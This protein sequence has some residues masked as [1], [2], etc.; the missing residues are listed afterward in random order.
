MLRLSLDPERP[1]SKELLLRQGRVIGWLEEAL[2]PLADDIGAAAVHALAVAIRSAIGI[3][4]YVW[5]IDVAHVAP[6]DATN[7]MRWTARCH[8]RTSGLASA[9]VRQD[10]REQARRRVEERVPPSLCSR[11]A[12]PIGKSER[13]RGTRAERLR[14]TQAS[15]KN[16][17]GPAW[18][19]GGTLVGAKHSISPCRRTQSGVRS[20]VRIPS[21][22]TTGAIPRAAAP[23][24]RRARSCL[25]NR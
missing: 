5:L 9:A 25:R 23:S 18:R 1:G 21:A 22:L 6:G 14:R 4:A 10:R 11:G 17:T 16:S 20:R 19:F 13:R 12:T 2:A 8:H 15:V 3:E 24:H 7:L